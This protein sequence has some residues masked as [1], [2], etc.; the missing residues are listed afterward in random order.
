MIVVAE[1]ILRTTISGLGIL[2]RNIIVPFAPWILVAVLGA[3]VWAFI[4]IV[5]PR[6]VAARQDAQIE[7]LT[8]AA[9]AWERTARGW[10]RSW[11]LSEGRRG[12][13]TQNA[14]EAAS[15]AASV[16]NARVAQARASARV[17]EKI[18]TKEPTYDAN[19]CPRREL[20]PAD[21]LRDAISP[22]AG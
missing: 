13:E 2:W 22:P 10:E 17:I 19:R 7:M 15:E 8:Q 3:V 12:L 6:A 18:V 9:T 14:R 1:R 16:C 20:V 11:S 4:P 21:Q 5:G